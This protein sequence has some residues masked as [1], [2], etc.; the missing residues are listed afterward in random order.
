VRATSGRTLASLA[1][2]DKEHAWVEHPLEAASSLLC[3]LHGEV[4]V[5]VA[6]AAVHVYA[7]QGQPFLMTTSMRTTTLM[8]HESRYKFHSLSP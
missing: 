6:G 1:E 2:E 3:L 5:A 8:A 4:L 7:G